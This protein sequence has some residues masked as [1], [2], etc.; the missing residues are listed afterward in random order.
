MWKI[1]CVPVM[2]SSFAHFVKSNAKLCTTWKEELSLRKIFLKYFNGGIFSECQTS[3]KI[4]QYKGESSFWKGFVRNP[5]L[6]HVLYAFPSHHVQVFEEY[7]MF[8]FNDLVG[9][10]GGHSGLF[11]GFSFYGFIAQLIAKLQNHLN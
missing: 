8:S 4:V 9:T 3:C 10:V 2:F 5:Q 6:I 11:I 1:K 7:L